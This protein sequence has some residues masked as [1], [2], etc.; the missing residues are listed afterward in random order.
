MPVDQCDVT[1]LE[2]AIFGESVL[3]EIG[4][5]PVPTKDIRSLQ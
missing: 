5:L 2:P 1:S 4:S 3:V